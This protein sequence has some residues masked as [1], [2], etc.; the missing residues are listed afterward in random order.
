VAIVAVAMVLRTSWLPRE[1]AAVL[2]VVPGALGA[3]ATGAFLVATQGGHLTV[4][5]VLASLYP[6][7]HRSRIEYW[8]Q[9]MMLFQSSI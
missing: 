3:L 7:K 2:G 4:T 6:A 1:R 8:F 5:A 9:I